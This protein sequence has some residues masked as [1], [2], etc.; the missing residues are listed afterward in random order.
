M[1]KYILALDQ[2]TSS[3]RA[4]LFNDKGQPFA[5]EAQPFTQIYPRPGWVEQNPEEIW[6]SQL[7][8]ARAVVQKA[9]VA[10]DQIVAIAITNQRETTIVWDR[11]TGSTRVQ[12]D[13]VAMQADGS[14]VREA[15]D[16]R[17]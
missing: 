12:R 8:V 10:P 4:I 9:Q 13:R 11:A 7:A 3:S 2:G 15:Q 1:E 6:S 14:S 5:I 17:I 16:G